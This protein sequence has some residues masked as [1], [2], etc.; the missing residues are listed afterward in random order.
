MAPGSRGRAG[1]FWAR[2]RNPEGDAVVQASG[3]EMK[4]SIPKKLSHVTNRLYKQGIFVQIRWTH[5]NKTSNIQCCQYPALIR[6]PPDEAAKGFV[7]NWDSWPT[8]ERLSPPRPRLASRR[9]RT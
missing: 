1:G 6:I 8:L 5:C 7:S 2:T 3:S 4:F 9:L